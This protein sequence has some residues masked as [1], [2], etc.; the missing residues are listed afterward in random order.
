MFP[1]NIYNFNDYN[2]KIKSLSKKLLYDT[3]WQFY[4]Y[5]VENILS[6]VDDNFIFLNNK[7]FFNVFGGFQPN[8]DLSKQ[9]II[10]K[11][12]INRLNKL[13]KDCVFPCIYKASNIQQYYL[14]EEG[15][16]WIIV[17]KLFKNEEDFKTDCPNLFNYLYPKLDTSKK[18][19][20]EF[21]NPRNLDKYKSSN[22]KLLSPRT[23]SINSFAYDNNKHIIK[24][25]NTAIISKKMNLKY[26]LGILNSSLASFYYKEY[27]FSYHG[28]SMK[29]EPANINSFMIPIKKAD[30]AV[31]KE[32]VN[33][34]DSI[35][36]KR[37]NDEDTTEET[38]KIDSIVY[39]LYGLTDEEI[40]LVETS[41]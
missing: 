37:I 38:K 33:L 34:V 6:N 27:G 7:S 28:S 18:K 19:W 40:T 32:I 30:L 12:D 10:K 16:Y 24:G 1:S 22:E 13:E 9:F 11:G 15:D 4:H 39:Q 5:I 23:A 17:N 25:T 26:V 2:V 20:W 14:K 8:V 35:L 3:R 29:Y 41:I 21:P 31:E 36:T